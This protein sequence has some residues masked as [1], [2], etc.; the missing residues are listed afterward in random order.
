MQFT[1]GEWKINPD[2]ETNE[3]GATETFIET[4][5][6]KNFISVYGDDEEAEANAKLIAAAPL[7]Y[8]ALKGIH[9]DPET[10][11][12]L[13]GLQQDKVTEALKKATE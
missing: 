6:V 1:K 7:M 5:N 3:W 4:D 10:F 11:N 8:N 12:D 2:K 9:D 13:F